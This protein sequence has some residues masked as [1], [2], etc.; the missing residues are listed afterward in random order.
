MAYALAH[1]NI[2][3]V[4]IQNYDSRFDAGVQQSYTWPRRLNH[5]EGNGWMGL[6]RPGFDLGDQFLTQQMSPPMAPAQ[7]PAYEDKLMPMYARSIS[8]S[9]PR[10]NLT[11]EQREL[12]RQRDFARRD[13]KVRMRRDRST[14]NPYTLSPK[15]SPEMLS[16]SLS[17]FSNTLAPSPL[18][19]QGSQGSPN[20]SNISSP[21]YLSGYTPNLSDA[22][23]NDMYGGAVFPPM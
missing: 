18:L 23:S 12:K 6:T 13:S 11:P 3:A 4:G 9:P 8:D 1:N 2:S 5:F 17:E 15:P 16:R 22:G 19:S 7:L 14:S 20:L 10:A 21:A